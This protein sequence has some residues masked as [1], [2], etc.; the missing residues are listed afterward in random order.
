MI[1]TPLRWALL[2]AALLALSACGFQLRGQA[3]LPSDI[4]P[5]FVQG[6]GEYDPIRR[7]LT[8]QLGFSD[9]E[10]TETKAEAGSVLKISARQ[11]E[12]RVLSVD[13]HGKVAEYEL[14]ESLKFALHDAKGEQL[15]PEQRVALNRDYINTG[16]QELGKQEEEQML[17]Q[18]MR[19]DLASEIMR[20]MQIGLAR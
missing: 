2:C 6:L 15:L 12:K 13:S 7:E 4:S 3:D 11:S 9:I 5:V 18:D 20:R 10:I 19:R 14:H 1:Q 17:R 8:A 16:E